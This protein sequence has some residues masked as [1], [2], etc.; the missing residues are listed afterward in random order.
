MNLEYGTPYFNMTVDRCRTT[1]RRG[2]RARARNL[3]V[4]KARSVTGREAT[5]PP[6]ETAADAISSI[7]ALCPWLRGVE[8]RPPRRPRS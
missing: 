4:R 2:G 8:F 6:E 7:D 5:P 1:G 3:Q